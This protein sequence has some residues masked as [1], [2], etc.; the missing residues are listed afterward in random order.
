[1][2]FFENRVFFGAKISKFKNVLIKKLTIFR[3]Y[4]VIGNPHLFHL[5]NEPSPIPVG[6]KLWDE[7]AFEC[8]K[9]SLFK[10]LVVRKSNE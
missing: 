9:T 2:E 6:W 3:N 7:Q 4:P 1:M 10:R 8:R 5:H